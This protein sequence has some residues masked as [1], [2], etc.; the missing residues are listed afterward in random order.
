MFVYALISINQK[1]VMRQ[2]AFIV[3]F[4]GFAIHVKTQ[5]NF[6]IKPEK[7]VPGSIIAFEW[8]TGNTLLQGKQNIE[9]T[10]YLL[11]VENKLPH[12]VPITLKKEGGIVSGSLKTNDSTKAVFFSFSKDDVVEN[13]NQVGYYTILYDKMVKK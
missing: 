2:L 13:N 9:G 7:P 11:Y 12:A 8:L 5:Q 6:K 4:F 3:L 1:I 10:A